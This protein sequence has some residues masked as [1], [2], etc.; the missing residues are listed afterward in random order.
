MVINIEGTKE[1]IQRIQQLQQIV[2]RSTFMDDNRKGI[3]YQNF[4]PSVE[5]RQVNTYLI[6]VCQPHVQCGS[7]QTCIQGMQ[8]TCKVL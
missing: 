6:L 2:Y 3:N 8:L 7:Y 5:S 4:N 1:Q